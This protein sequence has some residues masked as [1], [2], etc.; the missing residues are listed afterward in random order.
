MALPKS[1]RYLAAA[2]LCI[3][4]YMFLQVFRT[5]QDANLKL[6]STLPSLPSLKSGSWRDPQLDRRY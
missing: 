2:T 5:S 3:F 1:M 6:T 4:V